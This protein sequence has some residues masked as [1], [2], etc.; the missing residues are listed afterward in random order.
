MSGTTHAGRPVQQLRP[1]VGSARSIDRVHASDPRRAGRLPAG[2][3]LR[4][5]TVT[6][7]RRRRRRR[8]D[9]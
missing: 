6:Q 2:T 5:Y 9:A 7:G 8:L 4:S 3:V 1:E